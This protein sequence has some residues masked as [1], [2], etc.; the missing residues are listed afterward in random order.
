MGS[1]GGPLRPLSETLGLP[2]V[3]P[4]LPVSRAHH[5]PCR[6]RSTGAAAA[7]ARR[8]CLPPRNCSPPL[9]PS[10]PACQGCLEDQLTPEALAKGYRHSE[11]AFSAQR[12]LALT[13]T[14]QPP[15]FY[16]A[17]SLAYWRTVRV[18]GRNGSGGSG[19]RR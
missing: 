12:E 11:G 13:L 10:C 18:G 6:R 14:D 3:W 15:S 19:G 1:R 8:R 2:D 4:H 16:S 9:P 5:L 7:A 17:A